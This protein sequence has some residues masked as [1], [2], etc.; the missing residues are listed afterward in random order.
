MHILLKIFVT[1]LLL[2]LLVALGAE[3]TAL[4]HSP[5]PDTR[6]MAAPVV[7]R[8][9]IS[10]PMPLKTVRPVAHQFVVRSPLLPSNPTAQHKAPAR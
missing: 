2:V 8:K 3:V 4:H 6:H 9:S 1:G 7:V 5:P 10:A